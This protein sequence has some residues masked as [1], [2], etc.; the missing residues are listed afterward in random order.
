MPLPANVN[1]KRNCTGTITLNHSVLFTKTAP[2]MAPGTEPRPP[3]TTIVSARRLSTGAKICSPSACWCSTS[4]PP[5]NDAKKPESANAS[6]FT[7]VGL[8]RKACALRSLSRVATMSRST[9]ERCS[10][11]TASSTRIEAGSRHE[12][13]AGARCRSRGRRT[14]STPGDA[15]RGRRGRRAGTGSSRGR[16]A[17]TTSRPRRRAW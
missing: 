9:R 12:V 8:R 10:P 3:T 16:A 4:S 17:T 14:A 5:A 2:R 15:G 13:E 7:R 11:R 1:R 6:S